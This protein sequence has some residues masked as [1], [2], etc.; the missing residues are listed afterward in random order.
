M[1]GSFSFREA[2]G[3]AQLEAPFKLNSAFLVDFFFA[4]KSLLNEAHLLYSCQDVDIACSERSGKV[5]VSHC[6]Q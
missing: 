6:E 4:T 2:L 5:I 1:R 3:N